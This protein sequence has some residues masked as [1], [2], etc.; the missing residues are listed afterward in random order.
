MTFGPGPPRPG[1][2]LLVLLSIGFAGLRPSAAFGQAPRLEVDVSASRIA[3]DTLA[4]LN[5]PSL[6]LLTE[7]QRPSLFSRVSGSVTAFEDAGWSM[8]GSGS[9]AGWLSPFGVLS[10]LRL[11]LG[12]TAGGSHHSQGFDTGVG[13]LDGRLHLVG[14]RMGA[15]V[16]TSLARA[17]NSFDSA[18][19]G[20]V[21]PGAGLW[22][23][24]GAVRG[25]LSY[26]HTNLPGGG[27]PEVDVTLTY[28]SGGLDLGL[29]GGIREWP[30]EPGFGDESW[31]GVTAAYWVGANAAVIVSG[32]KYAWDVLQGLP[33]G[34]FFSVGFRLTP[35]R[36]RPIPTAAVAPIVY[37]TEEAR[38][39]AITFEVRG[40]RR[41][42]IA[43]D[44]NGW[45]KVPMSRDA[46]GRWMLPTELEPGTYR[47]NL[48]IDGER[49]LVPEGFTTIDDGFGGTVGILIV[50]ATKG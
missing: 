50:S 43:G 34:E 1:R 7:W 19:V 38:G 40:A 27:F 36:A 3:Y 5:A 2:G 39:G 12:G 49:W 37:T 4:P 6:S 28:T 15:W 41:V 21:V 17:K 13:R 18:S 29:Y 31:A 25:M 44:W 35:R 42:E 22:V 32:G 20:A 10:P 11:E 48:L 23:Q 26:E 47:F 24:D 14:P 16:G 46:R 30:G 33:G 9:L 45:E 8:Q